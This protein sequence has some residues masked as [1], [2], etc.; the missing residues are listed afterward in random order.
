MSKQYRQGD[1]FMQEVSEKIDSSKLVPIQAKGNRHILAEGEVTG[2]NHS[3]DCQ[4][5]GLFDY[6]GK[7]VMV[8][9]ETTFIEHQEHAPIEVSP[10]TYWVVRQREY[11]PQAIQRVLD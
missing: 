4:T 5:T 9:D 1:V 7:T 2:H 8:V 11:T 3:V 10:G 6:L